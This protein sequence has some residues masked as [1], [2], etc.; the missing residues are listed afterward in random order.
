MKI[1]ASDLQGLPKAPSALK[2]F[3]KSWRGWKRRLRDML[4]EDE[5][6]HSSEGDCI[7]ASPKD[8]LSLPGCSKLNVKCGFPGLVPLQLV[9]LS[10]IFLRPGIRTLQGRSHTHRWDFTCHCADCALCNSVN[11]SLHCCLEDMEQPMV[12]VFLASIMKPRVFLAE[13]HPW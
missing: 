12:T 4:P 11:S 13:H 5:V 10:K 3:T 8:T 1:R 9:V 6:G 2:N 7:D